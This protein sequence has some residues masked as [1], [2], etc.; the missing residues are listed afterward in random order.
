[1]SVKRYNEPVLRCSMLLFY[2]RFTY[3]LAAASTFECLNCSLSFGCL[4]LLSN[5]PYYINETITPASLRAPLLMGF[6]IVGNALLACSRV[7][8]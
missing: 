2:I 3:S 4:T 7:H 8:L 5:V 1:M 6:Y